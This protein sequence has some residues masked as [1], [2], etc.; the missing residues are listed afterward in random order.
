MLEGQEGEDSKSWR[1]LG[2]DVKISYREGDLVRY[3]HGI[4]IDQSDPVF[5]LLHRADGSTTQFHRDVIIKIETYGV[6]R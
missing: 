1:V 4:A 3:C 6:R 5:V 2:V